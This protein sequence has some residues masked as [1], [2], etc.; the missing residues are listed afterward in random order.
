MKKIILIAAGLLLLAACSDSDS[1]DVCES[2][3]Y[4]NCN[5][6][7]PSE[8]ILN[9]RVTINDDN[10]CVPVTVYVGDMEDHFIYLKDTV[11]S[12]W[13]SAEVPVGYFY[14]VTA[15]YRKGTEYVIAVDGDDVK[16]SKNN[17]CDSTCWS[18]KQ[19]SVNLK[20]KK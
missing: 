2:P 3:D 1:E 13:W 19:G 6:T 4:S 16:A 5:T 8:G 10:C 11:Y 9:V 14:T 17:Y 15:Q 12:D 20:L 7:K 18:V